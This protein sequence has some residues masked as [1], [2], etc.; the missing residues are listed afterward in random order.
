MDP[1][2]GLLFSGPVCVGLIPLTDDLPCFQLEARRR[3]EVGPHLIL[4][5]GVP[6]QHSQRSEIRSTWPKS[7]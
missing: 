1:I 5:A 7:R 2:E 4:R 6:E 3:C